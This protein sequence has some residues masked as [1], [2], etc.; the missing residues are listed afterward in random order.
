M[1]IRD[2]YYEAALCNGVVLEGKI[3][4]PDE[5]KLSYYNEI[6]GSDFQMQVSFFSSALKK[7]L[8]RVKDK[9][10]KEMAAALYD[11]LDFFRKNG[12]NE[13]MLKNAYIK[14]MCWLYYCFERITNRLGENEIPK[15]L[16]EGEI[17]SYELMMLVILS[18]VGCD[19]ILLQYKG[20]QSYQKVDPKSRWSDLLELAD[21]VSFPDGFC[22][23]QIQK[24]RENQIEE[25]RIYGKK[26]EIYPCTNA[27]I[28]GNGL[29]DIKTKSSERGKNSQLFYNCLIRI[30][31]VEDKLTYQTELYQFQLEL[32]SRKGGWG[33]SSAGK[34]LAA[35][36]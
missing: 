29:E 11:S 15:I 30:N 1:C 35:Q 18:N 31:G 23:R 16:Y 10:R 27:W 21:A 4:N 2:R 20:E 8:P 14:Y 12:K 7:W 33:N 24:N 3:P 32:K 26:P 22:I 9:Q 5:K 6:M 13:N 28:K 36:A 34:G 19:V 17:G 25:S